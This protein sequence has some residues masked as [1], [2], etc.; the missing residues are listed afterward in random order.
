MSTG[1]LLV[2]DNVSNMY[3]MDSNAVRRSERIQETGREGAAIMQIE[4]DDGKKNT[5]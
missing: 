5:E 1:R 4:R 2:I 3:R